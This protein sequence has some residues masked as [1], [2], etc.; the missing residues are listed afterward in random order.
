MLSAYSS[1]H[2]LIYKHFLV[3]KY[4]YLL[5]LG[6]LGFIFIVI[7]KVYP[8]RGSSATQDSVLLNKLCYMN[9]SKEYK[10]KISRL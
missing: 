10:V 3:A 9:V 2:V 8:M 1:L 4:H 5:T 7:C 6:D